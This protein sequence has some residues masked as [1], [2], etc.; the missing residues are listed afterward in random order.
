MWS[1]AS[2]RYWTP[3]AEIFS[4]SNKLQYQLKVEASLADVQAKLGL[5]SN[6]DANKIKNA[7]SK[8]TLNRVKEIEKDIHHD[9]MAVVNAL[10]EAAGDSGEFVH[11][12]ATS[13]DIQDTVLALQLNESRNILLNLLDELSGVIAHHA[14]KHKNTACIGRTHGQ[15]AVPTTVGFKFA[16]FL[17]E[18]H[19]AK[20]ELFNSRIN[21]SKFSGAV[22]NYAT[23]M[24]MDVEEELF[25]VLELIPCD[26]ST[27]VVPRVIHS[28]FLNSLALIASV[29]ERISKEIR[30]LQRSEINEWQ[31]PFSEKQ[32]GSSAM[33]HKR[34]P[35]KSERISGLVRIIRSNVAISL[36]NI[37][38]EHERDISHSSVERVII[39]ESSNLLYYITKSMISILNGLNINVE[40]ITRN[41]ERADKSKSEQILNNISKNLGRQKGHELLRKHVNSDNFKESMFSDAELLKYISKTE[42]DNIFNTFN[43]GLA[44]TKV[45]MII[46]RYNSKWKSYRTNII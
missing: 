24:R 46:D 33:P 37:A 28:Q 43:T 40:S 10:S 30:N 1:D 13:N 29:I 9:L 44:T 3:V 38:L 23:S 2:E 12:G 4:A 34:N 14:N 6:K 41:L 18:L 27:Q 21:L 7:I 39:P 35:H 19:L 16:N 11:L 26:I 5:I 36:E 25:K 20:M 15:F 8:V 32:V 22:G 45:E 17:Y 31:E 42:L